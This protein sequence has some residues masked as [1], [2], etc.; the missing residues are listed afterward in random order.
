VGFPSRLFSLSLNFACFILDPF[1]PPLYYTQ[2]VQRVVGPAPSRFNPYTNTVGTAPAA[3]A[4]ARFTEQD[5]I[6]GR[7][8]NPPTLPRPWQTSDARRHRL[9]DATANNPALAGSIVSNK[10]Y[11]TAGVAARRPAPPTNNPLEQSSSNVFFRRPTSLASNNRLFASTTTGTTRNDLFGGSG[12]GAGSYVLPRQPQ[13]R[14]EEAVVDEDEPIST[15]RGSRA[16]SSTATGD[17][18]WGSEANGSGGTFQGSR[19]ASRQDPTLQ[20]VGGAEIT[21]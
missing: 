3:T 4:A 20:H 9:R 11:K 7:S 8:K 21:F 16:K 14:Q 2:P 13:G 6:S 15:G 1:L 18:V 10:Q 5:S 12:V 17:G 19:S